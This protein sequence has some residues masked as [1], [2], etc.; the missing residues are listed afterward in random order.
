MEKSCSWKSSSLAAGQEIPLPVRGLNFPYRVHNTP[1][2]DPAV[3]QVISA[4]T[5]IS[6]FFEICIIQY[7]LLQ[8]VVGLLN[9]NFNSE[10]LPVTVWMLSIWLKELLQV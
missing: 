4:H 5:L 1:P 10:T 6:Y 2:Q 9:N 8:F 7:F 3:N